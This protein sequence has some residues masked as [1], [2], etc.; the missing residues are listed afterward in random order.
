MSENFAASIC[1]K[2]GVTAG[3]SIKVGSRITLC[4]LKLVN[5]KMPTPLAACNLRLRPGIH[6]IWQAKRRLKVVGQI[7]CKF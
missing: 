5:N 7:S 2:S 4:R 3:V 6:T 1:Q